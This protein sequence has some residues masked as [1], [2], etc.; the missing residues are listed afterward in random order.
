MSSRL[1]RRLEA[2]IDAVLKP[3]LPSGQSV[4]LL[5]FPNHPNVG[6]SAIW[7][8]EASWLARNLS[9]RRYVCQWRGYNPEALRERLPRG[10]ILLHGGGNFG[11]LW[12][13]H[14]LFRERVIR[15]F[16]DR[17]IIQLPQT[18]HFVDSARMHAAARVVNAHPNFTLLVRDARSLQLSRDIFDCPSLLCPD[19]AFC[20]GPLTSPAS[21]R[22][23]KG[24]TVFL[25]RTDREARV[26]DVGRVDG[27]AVP[28]S[29]DWMHE[30]LVHKVLPMAFR[31]ASGWL[32][33]RGAPLL[34]PAITDRIAR[35]RLD[36]GL[37]L[38]TGGEQ[39]VTDRLHGHILCVLL[40]V[41]H[42][43]IDNSYGKLSSFVETWAH[44]HDEVK[45]FD[46]SEQVS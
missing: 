19:M 39:V 34:P 28:S 20:L 6:D 10:P 33:R 40:G 21:T 29:V 8:G 18:I 13:A 38:L 16:P 23:R 17:Q 36:R 4:A 35:T 3:L 12:M 42:R 5:D 2:S 7:L 27:E 31:V 41:P 46:R 43:L 9:V 32:P 22:D 14:Q 30:P 24:G 25:L 44:D 15:D 11:D 45:W 26:A 37:R 1:I